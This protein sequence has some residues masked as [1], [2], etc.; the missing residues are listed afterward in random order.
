MTPKFTAIIDGKNAGTEWGAYPAEGT[1]AAL[2]SLPEAGELIANDW[3]ERNGEEVSPA[4]VLT[5]FRDVTLPFV[6]QE[7]KAT[8]LLDHFKSSPL[9]TITIPELSASAVWKIAL[10]DTGRA[11]YFPDTRLIDPVFAVISDPAETAAT[12]PTAD[13]T[14]LFAKLHSLGFQDLTGTREEMEKGAEV[15][16]YLTGQ[17]APL[18]LQSYDITIPLYYGGT[19]IMQARTALTRYLLQP[20]ERTLTY[21]GRTLKAVYLKSD[22]AEA[23]KRPDGRWWWDLSITLQVTTF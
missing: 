3:H 6:V 20:G 16:E 22:T 10:R 21:E 12:N 17:K 13:G 18:T 11:E 19:D 5:A 2:L 8:A 23:L 15:K 9:H 7:S 4:P 1:L 14:E